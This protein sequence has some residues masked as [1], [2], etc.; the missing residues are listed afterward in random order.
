MHVPQGATP[1]DGP[2]A[3]ITLTTA[4]IS[5]LTGNPVRKDV[6]MT[7]EVTLRG[8]VLPIGG[9]KE[10]TLAALR[11]GITTLIIPHR[12]HKDL[13]EV[14]KD[15]RKK[16]KFILAKDV[17]EVLKN[18]LVN[19]PSEWSKQLKSSDGGHSSAGSSVTRVA[20]SVDKAA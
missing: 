17:H 2:S 9:L 14:P 6:A 18:A 15:L 13:D 20:K 5:L 7:G 10:K 19:E 12:N 16:C 3:G 1:K 11:H 8:H 4:L